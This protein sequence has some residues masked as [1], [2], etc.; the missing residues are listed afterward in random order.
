VIA[1]VDAQL[2][3][4]LAPWLTE[5]FGLEAYS[6]RFLGL[7]AA[8]DPEIFAAARSAADIVLTKDRDFVLLVERFGPP[9]QV[10]W[11][12][13][14]NTSNDRL[15]Q[16]L[17]TNFP[18]AMELLKRGEPIVEIGDPGHAGGEATG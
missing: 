15:R 7:Q 13:C 2:S 1:W 12:T 9:P 10:V 18:K 5:T 4:A 17:T 11:I 3:P 8:K 16:V 6:A 14:G